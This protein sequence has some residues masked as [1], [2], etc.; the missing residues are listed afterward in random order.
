MTSLRLFRL[1]PVALWAFFAGC[2]SVKSGLTEQPAVDAAADAVADAAR[3]DALDAESLP[4]SART[5]SGVDAQ[6][7]DSGRTAE[8]G[9]ASGRKRVF[10]TSATFS[11]KFAEP[12]DRSIAVV[13][14]RVDASCNQAAG[15]AKLSGTYRAWIGGE[16]AGVR[17]TDE[18]HAQAT[19]GP[20]EDLLG[21]VIFPMPIVTAD[22]ALLAPSITELRTR[23]PADSRAWT[24]YDT[25]NACSGYVDGRQMS[26]SYDGSGARGPTGNPTNANYWFGGF[27]VTCSGQAHLYCF[28]E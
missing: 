16:F 11:P 3:L 24:G 6:A 26:W 27:T 17:I 15:A 1:S 4:D 28:E 21:N 25:L 20:Y 2:S 5:D 18:A 14:G 13:L 12:N 22:A 19:N 23:L 9:S 10:V 7:S 8:S